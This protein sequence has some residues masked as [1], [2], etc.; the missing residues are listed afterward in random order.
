MSTTYI[1]A[2]QSRKPVT[3]IPDGMTRER[4]EASIQQITDMLK[5][6]MSDVERIM[7]VHD[8]GDLRDILALM[9]APR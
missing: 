5:G 7:L 8:R 9:D 1:K 3:V 4:A 2:L 6:P